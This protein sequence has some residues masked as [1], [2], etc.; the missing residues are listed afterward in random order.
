MANQSKSK[1]NL[2]WARDLD[3][4][5]KKPEQNVSNLDVERRAEFW[6]QIVCDSNWPNLK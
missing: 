6:I 2:K 1:G 4:G 3:F 5:K